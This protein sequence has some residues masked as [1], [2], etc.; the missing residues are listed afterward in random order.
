M[1]TKQDVKA[2]IFG[3]G[4]LDLDG[5]SICNLDN[6]MKN[7][8]I[9]RNAKYQVWSD[10]HRCYSLYANIDEAV[11]KFASLLKDKIYG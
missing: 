5:V 8:I 10:R 3:G 4:S 9:K 6:V 7:A 1:M 2:V 11:E